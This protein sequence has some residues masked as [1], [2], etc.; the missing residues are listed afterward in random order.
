MHISQTLQRHFTPKSYILNWFPSSGSSCQVVFCTSSEP[1]CQ[2]IIDSTFP[3]LLEQV[4]DDIEVCA[5]F[6]VLTAK[7]L[8]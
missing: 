1:P 8:S 2:R 3:L 6:R 7:R 5:C 4:K